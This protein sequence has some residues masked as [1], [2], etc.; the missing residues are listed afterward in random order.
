M[1]DRDALRVKQHRHPRAKAVH[2]EG[3]A[4]IEERQHHGAAEVAALPY[5][6]P[7]SAALAGRRGSVDARRLQFASGFR[8]HATLDRVDDL[9][10]LGIPALA[11]EPARRLGQAAPH[12]PDQDRAR[13]PDDHDPAPAVE[14][15]DHVGDEQVRQHGDG[16]YRGQDDEDAERHV[17]PARVV[18]R[19]LRDVGVDSNQLDADADAGEEAPE[20]HRFG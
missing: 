17:A 8:D 15:Q 2:A 16:R 6:R 13:G 11:L 14:A 3:L 1:R 10:S 4:E 20:V 12:E 18:R 19:Q 5:L 9:A 7:G